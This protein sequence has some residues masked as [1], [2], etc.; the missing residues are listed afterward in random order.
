MASSL[1]SNQACMALLSA[2]CI[3]TGGLIRGLVAQSEEPR[4]T[5]GCQHLSA[6]TR[7]WPSALRGE[8][9]GRR[10]RGMEGTMIILTLWLLSV[11]PKDSLGPETHWRARSVSPDEQ[12]RGSR[13]RIGNNTTL[14]IEYIVES[15]KDGRRKYQPKLEN[16][17]R[18]ELSLS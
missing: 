7:R 1:A 15:K 11:S 6:R 9:K 13:G 16:R 17:R 12:R 18:L 14:K 3:Q 4:A 10:A 5:N 8:G 2:S